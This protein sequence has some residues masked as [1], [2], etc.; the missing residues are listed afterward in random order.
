V[1]RKYQHAAELDPSEPHLFDWGAEL[2]KHR[3]ADPAIE[4]FTKG[5]RLFPR[6]VRMLLGLGVA[7]YAR[8]SYDKAARRFFG[9]CDLNPTDPEPYL[10]LGKVQAREITQSEVYLDRLK[11]FVELQP[12]N[13]W[14]NY[15]YAVVLWKRQTDHEDT[16]AAAVRVLLEKAVHLDPHLDTAYLQLGIISADQKDSRAAIS[17]YRK[18]IEINPQLEEAHYRLSQ[19]YAMTGEKLEAQRELALY[20]QLSKKAA[21]QLERERAELQQF[22]FVLKDRP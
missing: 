8:G 15:Y 20:N 13:A 17:A 1:V 21:E 14:A 7:F 4:V 11:R 18:A 3:A 6:S 22:V 16:T 12:D 2:L 19:A 10:F 9:A 5:N